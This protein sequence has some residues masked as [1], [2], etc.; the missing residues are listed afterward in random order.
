MRKGCRN[1]YLE[2]FDAVYWAKKAVI[3]NL[4]GLQQPPF[5]GRG[6]NFPSMWSKYLSNSAWR[7]FRIP[8][9]TSAMVT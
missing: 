7:D 5:G 6:L 9:S 4:R 8:M 2:A 3:K 1:D